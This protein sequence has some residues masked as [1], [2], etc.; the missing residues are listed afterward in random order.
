M[1]GWIHVASSYALLLTAGVIFGALLSRLVF[2]HL[3]SRLTETDPTTRARL[4]FVLLLLPMFVAFALA[5]AFSAPLAYFDAG[6]GWH[7]GGDMQ[8]NAALCQ[9]HA[10]QVVLPG[11]LALTGLLF[12]LLAALATLFGVRRLMSALDKLE[13]LRRMAQPAERS[14]YFRLE[15]SNPIGFAAGLKRGQIFVSRGLE[16]SLSA[17]ELEIVLAH[18]RVH[19]RRHDILFALAVQALSY[20]LWP[21]TGRNLR[22]QWRLAI[23]Q[24]CDE[25]VAEQV[26]DRLRVAAC[27]VTVARLQ[28]GCSAQPNNVVA[29][30]LIDSDLTTRVESLLAG[31]ARP[32][33]PVS[34]WIAGIVAFVSASSLAIGVKLHH[35]T[36]WLLPVVGH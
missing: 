24:R 25:T 14:D 18:E 4:L 27:L 2:G 1:S 26:G 19:I 31:P 15:T 12:G 22:A 20:L 33:P 10:P 17:G 5:V 11:W 30:H 7:C 3:Q 8:G 16:N 36:E 6:H 23:E 9:W 32:H 34:A 13:T 35:W 28:K 29:C 21:E